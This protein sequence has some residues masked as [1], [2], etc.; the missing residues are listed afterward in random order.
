MTETPNQGGSS[1]SNQEAG[2]G[3][4]RASKYGGLFAVSAAILSLQV[5][6]TRIFAFSLDAMTIYLAVGMCLLGLG[7]SGTLL[8]VLPPLSPKRVRSVAWMSAALSALVLVASHW[9]FTQMSHD[10]MF[11]GALATLTYLA[12]AAPYFCFGL[13]VTAILMSCGDQIGKAYAVNLGGSGL[14]CCIVFPLLDAFG[15]ELAL[16]AV[17]GIALFG[18][19]LIAPPNIRTRVALSVVAAILLW[20]GSSAETVF[21]F[22]P[23]RVHQLNGVLGVVDELRETNPKYTFMAQRLFKRWDRTGRI[24]VY[25][26]DSNV[27]KLKSRI[28]KPLPIHFW[29]QDGGAGSFMAGVKNDP[30]R[31]SDLYERSVYGAGYALG[32]VKD[33]LI[34]GLG[35]GPDV[36]TSLYHGTERI[37]AV[38]I[39]ETAISIIQNEF[40]NFLGDPYND[41][42]VTVHRVDGRGFVRRSRSPDYDLIQLS[43]VDTKSVIA[44]GSLS[45]N[46]NYLYTREAMSEYLSRLRDDGL[47]VMARLATHEIFRLLELARL[48]LADLGVDNP[49]NHIFVIEQEQWR[50]VLVK[51]TPFEPEEI[52]TLH[53]W[54]EAGGEPDIVIPAFNWIGAG[55][56][57]PMRVLYSPAPREVAKGAFIEAL[58]EGRY[59][60]YLADQKLDFSAP[61]DDRPFFFFF[62]RP[63]DAV[64]APV[65]ELWQVYDTVR[66]ISLIALVLILT[67]LVVFQRRG[68]RASSAAKPLAYFACLGLG[69]MLLE[70]GL[71][72]GFVLLLGHT[73]YA[74]T[75]VIFGLLLGA[76]CGSVVSGRFSLTDKRGIRLAFGALLAIAIGYAFGLGSLFEVAAA[77]PF[78]VRLGIALTLLLILGVALGIPFPFALRSVGTNSPTL[79]AWGIGIN[80]FAS[81]VGATAAVPISM[82]FGMKVLLLLGASLYVVALLCIPFPNAGRDP[83]SA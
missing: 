6:Q 60:E 47:L 13:T 73:S 76:T 25:R 16:V 30:S 24:D 83:A 41:E 1:D 52:E 72:H 2:G 79:V 43:G 10:L 54:V 39:N 81:V 74:V 3:A 19:A 53:A 15:A 33:A 29:A 17:A 64:F 42:R 21:A 7:A 68:L 27:P 37:D 71:I 59:E 32:P 44:S 12:L 5:L 80:G 62:A 77:T 20:T 11:G 49:R 8:A 36:M 38:E 18:A 66:Q 58:A 26:I 67:P 9:V 69:F 45:V 14:G 63:M 48:G 70:I 31:A 22:K 82:I 50:S 40:A 46:Q 23:D 34:I 75:V 61:T 78:A 28:G 57:G 35:G 4:S 51:R 56:D 55:L 65:A